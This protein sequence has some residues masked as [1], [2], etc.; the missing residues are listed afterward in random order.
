MLSQAELN[1]LLEYDPISG[2]LTFKA[3]PGTDRATK[4]WNAKH[5]GKLALNIPFKG[6]RRGSL[7]N[8]EL[9]AHRVIWKM[10]FGS[11]PPDL[12]T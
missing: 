10:V 9:L 3:R 5:A 4:S 8:K 12:T 2:S 6:Y 11:E 1:A 7:E